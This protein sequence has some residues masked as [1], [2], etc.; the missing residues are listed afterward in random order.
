MKI[1]QKQKLHIKNENSIFNVAIVKKT[2][3]LEKIKF[4]MKII[5]K[6]MIR[7]KIIYSS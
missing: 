6:P 4:W 2:F 7:F 5:A 1:R 3:N